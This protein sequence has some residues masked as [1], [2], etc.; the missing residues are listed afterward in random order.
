MTSQLQL[1]D[2]VVDVVHKDIKNLHLSVHPPTGRVT[3]AAPLR[4]KP[5]AIRVFAITKLGWIKQ[6]QLKQREQPRETLRDY[7]ERESHYVWGKRYL[8]SLI[9]EEA[10]PRVEVGARRLVLRVRPGTRPQKRE[11]V[12]EQWHRNLLREACPP[13]IAKWEKLLGVKVVR[14]HVQRMKTRWGS[15]NRK[16]KA[17]RLNTELA[18]KPRECLEYILVHEMTH[19]IE[20]THNS[21]F[22]ALMDQHLPKWRGIR[23]I[24]NQLPVRA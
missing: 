1:G 20:P 11:A 19:L 14:T 7:I 21:R 23:E 17:I 13:L 22:Q 4:M 15:C 3:I 9:E 12:M 18:K 16:A 8:L 5:E 6:Q 2:V 24:L 10:P